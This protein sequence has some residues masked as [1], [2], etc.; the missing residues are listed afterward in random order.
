MVQSVMHVD[1]R[2]LAFT[3]APEY[4]QPMLRWIYHRAD[5]TVTINPGRSTRGQGSGATPPARAE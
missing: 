1:A 5:L 3:E 4:I 2:D